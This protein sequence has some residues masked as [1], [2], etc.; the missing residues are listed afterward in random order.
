MTQR[1]ERLVNSGAMRLIALLVALLAAAAAWIPLS[2]VLNSPRTVEVPPA[3]SAKALV[4]LGIGA[5]AR[6]CV[7]RRQEQLQTMHDQGILSA[8]DLEQSR[9]RIKAYCYEQN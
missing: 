8:D 3:M 6:D 7:A 4:D 1:T 9:E 2:N 5:D